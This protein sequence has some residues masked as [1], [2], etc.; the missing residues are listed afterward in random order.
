MGAG[1]IDWE[2]LVV[3]CVLWFGTDRLHSTV[4]FLV[5]WVREIFHLVRTSLELEQ[6]WRL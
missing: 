4:G 1:V 3:G 6:C 5:I 2:R